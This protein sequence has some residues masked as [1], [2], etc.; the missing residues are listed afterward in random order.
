MTGR[1]H[2]P[3][4]DLSRLFDPHSIAVIGAS[5]RP[6]SP[7]ARLIEHL[8]ASPYTG[9]LHLVNPRRAEVGGRPCL[10]SVSALSE[11]VDLCLVVVPA[12]AVPATL[13]EIGGRGI[14]NVVVFSGGF[15]ETATGHGLEDELRSVADEFGL[16]V[17]GPNSVGFVAHGAGLPATFGR[18]LGDSVL[19]S[20]RTRTGRGVAIVS[21]SGG[22][23]ST[24]YELGRR[25]GLTF[26]HVV[27]SGNEAVLDAV[28]YLDHFGTDQTAGAVLVYAERIGRGREFLRACA[29]LGARGTSVVALLGGRMAGGARAALSHTGAVA[30]SYA[31]TRQ[32]LTDAGVV[33]AETPE[34][35][36]GALTIL[37]APKPRP[38]RGEVTVLASSGGVGVLAADLV[39]ESGLTLTSLDAERRAALDEHLPDYVTATNP[40]DVT[41]ALFNAPGGMAAVL[42]TLVATGDGEVAAVCSSLPGENSTD[43]ARGLAP[44]LTALTVPVV[45][46]WTADDDT[47]RDVFHD[48]AVPYFA[49]QRLGFRSLAA[50]VRAERARLAG[51]A[52]VVDAPAAPPNAG[53]EGVL[54]YPTLRASFAAA[55]LPVLPSHGVRDKTELDKLVAALDT[56]L[57]LKAE[58]EQI[59]H[60]AKVG[61]V[62]LGVVGPDA[63]RRAYDEIISAVA[64]IPGARLDSVTVEPQIQSPVEVYLGLRHDAQFGPVMALGL[65]GVLVERLGP[66]SFALLPLD[67]VAAGR[68]VAGGEQWA[69]LLDGPRLDRLASLADDVCRWWLDE[70]ARLGVVEVDVNPILFHGNEPVVVDILGVTRTPAPEGRTA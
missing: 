13:R 61:C 14:R 52:P 41:P 63:A 3:S 39:E 58:S 8:D 30:S 55:G 16:N 17:L 51:V 7:A 43:A 1:Q 10:P 45:V 18:L 34:E 12:A 33:V 6:A 9:A 60:R 2:T 66:P 50:V 32:L 29:R 4:R 56:T 31:V 70:G 67:D 35:A 44:V 19:V 65:G 22:V 15:A 69:R 26:T 62:K 54:T 64:A 59:P 68:L 11:P 53:A 20:R 27:S 36:I 42:E 28:D 47:I 37:V 48:A 46:M 23:A 38:H 49:D 40:L 57:V 21:Q 24:V 5:D 25:A